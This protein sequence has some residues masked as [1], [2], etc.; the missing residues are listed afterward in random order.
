M[1]DNEYLLNALD[2]EQLEKLRSS[3]DAIVFFIDEDNSY[4]EWCKIINKSLREH[5]MHEIQMFYTC[6][7]KAMN[8]VIYLNTGRKPYKKSDHG[9]FIMFTY[10][11]FD[12]H[13]IIEWKT[14]EGARWLDDVV[15][16]TY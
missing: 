2:T 10:D 13:Q 6:D 7:Q 8:D 3:K 16:S 11:T 12:S 1:T 9:K 4:D 15:Y 14:A 5:G